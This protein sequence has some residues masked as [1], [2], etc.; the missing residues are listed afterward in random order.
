MMGQP[1][2]AM[3]E[4]L[5]TYANFT[6]LANAA[7]APALSVPFGTS[8]QGLPIASHFFGKHGDERTLLELAFEIESLRPFAR[9]QDN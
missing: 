1:Y 4:N 8:S 5:S 2:E 3:I 7:G 9:I 6:P